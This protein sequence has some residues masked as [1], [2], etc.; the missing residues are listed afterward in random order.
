MAKSKKNNN[1]ICY[2]HLSVTTSGGAENGKATC[3]F[4]DDN[5]RE[6]N[7]WPEFFETDSASHA[8]Q[9]LSLD[10]GAHDYYI[11]CKDTANNEVNKTVSF[12]IDKDT[13]QPELE[14]MYMDTSMLHIILDEPSRCEY[15]TETFNYGEGN[16][17]SGAGT[18][19]NSVP[20]GESYYY[21]L[22]GDNYN[23]NWD[24]PILVYP[25]KI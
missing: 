3:Q 2:I 6:V 18:D 14:Y 15:S 7:L 20:R 19:H 16:P 21:I 17:M 8:Q 5:T 1:N 4:S 12:I 24:D 13:K 23:N 22:C 25:L 11:T 10:Q 9:L